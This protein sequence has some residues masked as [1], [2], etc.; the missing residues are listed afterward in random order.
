M[1]TWAAGDRG[2]EA[3]TMRMY[4]EAGDETIPGGRP[5]QVNLEEAL[6]ELDD[7]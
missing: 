4:K 7:L 6:R 3:K 2:Y 1:G 5:A